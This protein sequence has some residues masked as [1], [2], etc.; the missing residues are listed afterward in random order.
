[1]LYV[2]VWVCV[3]AEEP[4]QKLKLVS[5]GDITKPHTPQAT[6]ADTLAREGGDTLTFCLNSP[7]EVLR[8]SFRSFCIFFSSA[9]G[10]TWR[11]RTPPHTH[12][13]FFFSQER[14]HLPPSP[15]RAGLSD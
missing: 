2:C 6:V 8:L 12:T 14:H 5:T 11:R 4:W 13:V 9:G 1:M 7:G 15:S 3:R 10:T